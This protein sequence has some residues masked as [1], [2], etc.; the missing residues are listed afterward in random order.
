MI[1]ILT[2][3]PFSTAVMRYIPSD[4]SEENA[5]QHLENC[6]HPGKLTYPLKTD[7]WKMKCPFK[8]LPFEGIF[9]HF[10]GGKCLPRY[11]PSLGFMLR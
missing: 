3:T 9:F 7:D 2:Y 1:L 8:M 6:R 10:R 11:L 5:D 4:W